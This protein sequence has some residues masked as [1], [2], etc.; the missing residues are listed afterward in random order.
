MGEKADLIRPIYEDW[1]RGNWR[2]AFDVY[3]RERATRSVQAALADSPE[4]VSR[5]R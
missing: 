3:G 2:P 4:P 5:D 1:A